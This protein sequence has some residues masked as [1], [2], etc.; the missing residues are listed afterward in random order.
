MR[1]Q[2]RAALF[3]GSLLG[4]TAGTLAE[5]WRLLADPPDRVPILEA[6]RRALRGLGLEEELR[7]RLEKR[8]AEAT[9]ELEE[10]DRRVAEADIRLKVFWEQADPPSEALEAALRA[11]VESRSGYEVAEAELFLELRLELPESAWHRF[12]RE[13]FD[14]G[15]PAAPARA[16]PGAEPRQPA[17]PYPSA[18]APQGGGDAASLPRLDRRPFARRPPFGPPL[19][20]GLWWRQEPGRSGHSFRAS[21]REVLDRELERRRPELDRLHG[22]LRAA[23]RRLEEALSEQPHGFEPE[24]VRQAIRELAERRQALELAYLRFRAV[25]WRSLSVEERRA[26]LEGRGGGSRPLAPRPG[27]VPGKVPD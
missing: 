26:F 17:G 13:R 15:A 24:V 8:L 27:K 23:E 16:R 22:Q 5:P 3:L 9:E 1:R 7:A 19:P 21:L 14:P 25:Q 12:E 2:R 20:V 10:L 11:A 6:E 18:K 4:W